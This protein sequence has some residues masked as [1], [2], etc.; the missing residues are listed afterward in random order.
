MI[1][2]RCIKKVRDLYLSRLKWRRYR[3]GKNFHAGRGVVL[4]EKSRLVIGEN[5]YIGRYSQIEC[6]ADTKD[7]DYAWKGIWPKRKNHP[8]GIDKSKLAVY[9]PHQ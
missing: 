7:A 4:W 9:I 5:F 1:P 8:F 3:I 2:I 6:D